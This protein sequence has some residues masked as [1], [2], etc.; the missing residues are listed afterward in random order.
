[1]TISDA[2]RVARQTKTRRMEN[3]RSASLLEKFT[4]NRNSTKKKKHLTNLNFTFFVCKYERKKNPKTNDFLAILLQAK[5]PLEFKAPPAGRRTNSS[6]DT[7]TLF[8]FS[9]PF[10][11]AGSDG[12]RPN[13]TD[14]AAVFAFS[15]YLF[16][17]PPPPHFPSPAPPPR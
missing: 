6:S 5:L 2:A 8:S 11:S 14:G 17:C 3:N 15:C 4:Q 1:M 16:M 12:A 7:Q 10:V 9:F 13:R